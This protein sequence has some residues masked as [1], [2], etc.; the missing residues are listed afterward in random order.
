MYDIAGK[1]ALVTGGAKGIGRAYCEAL[2]QHGAKVIIVDRD[3][4]SGK[5]T[6]QHLNDI[7][8]NSSLF[9]CC[10][11]T[12]QAAL[13]ASFDGAVSSFGK[14]DIVINNAGKVDETEEGW[15]STVE[16]NL[17]AVIH[18]CRLAVE[19]L[20]AGGVIINTSSIA[21]SRE[22]TFPIYSAT[23]GGVTALSKSLGAPRQFRVTQIRVMAIQPGYT[24]T[25]LAG[26]D[27]RQFVWIQTEQPGD[28]LKDRLSKYPSQKTESVAECMIEAL[29]NGESGSVWTVNG[30]QWS[31]EKY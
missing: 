20:T 17:M 2:V 26:P 16:L 3:S 22:S 7:S 29:Q 15:R 21:A 1:V 19:Y 31:Q 14:L 13:K 30:G 23:K 6:E 18:G 11:V 4:A 8:P 25:T 24:P 28:T 12:N 9:I 5:V 10:D 27:L